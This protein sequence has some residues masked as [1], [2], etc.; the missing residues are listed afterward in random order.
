[1]FDYVSAHCDFDLDD[2]EP[3][4]LHDTLAHNV[5]SQ[6]QVLLQKNGGSQDTVWTNTH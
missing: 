2:S 1:M 4:F 3:I 5:A 6:Y